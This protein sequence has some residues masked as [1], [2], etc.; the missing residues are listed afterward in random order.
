MPTSLTYIVLSTRGSSPWRPAAVMS[1]TRQ[2]NDGLPRIFKGRRKRTGL[3][4]KRGALPNVK[5]SLRINR[6]QGDSPLKRR[7]NSS[8]GSRRRLRVRLR[9]RSCHTRW[10]YPCAGSGI[11]TRFPFDRWPKT[12]RFATGLAYLLG[13]TYPCP[14]A[15]HME[16][17]STSVFK[18]LI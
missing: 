5:P 16:P 8:R 10:P 3:R 9:Y 11:L 6:F 4:R 14:T 18:V 13:S 1:T 12:G 7:E 2:E 15:V 17:F